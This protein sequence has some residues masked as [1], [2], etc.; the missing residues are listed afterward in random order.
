MMGMILGC[1]RIS[2]TGKNL[3]FTVTFIIISGQKALRLQRLYICKNWG[4]TKGICNFSNIPPSFPEYTSR[5]YVG[6]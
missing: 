6:N 3:L 1:A 5:Y 4:V 2:V